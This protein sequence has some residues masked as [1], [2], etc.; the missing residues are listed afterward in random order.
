MSNSMPDDRREIWF[1]LGNF[2][3]S[4]KLDPNP[5]RLAEPTEPIDVQTDAFLAGAAEHLSRQNGIALPAWAGD[6]KYYLKDP[7]FP[8]GLTGPYRIFLLADS[9]LA[10][11]SRNIYVE[12][13]VLSRC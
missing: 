11:K 9:P 13:N 1:A 5:A 8:S 3:D 4:F 12:A 7:F 10:F 6:E 2:L